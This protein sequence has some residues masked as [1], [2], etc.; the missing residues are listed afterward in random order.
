MWSKRKTVI[1]N[2][3]FAMCVVFQPQAFADDTSPSLKEQLEAIEEQLNKSERTD[4]QEENTHLKELISP[5]QFATETLSTIKIE[6]ESK[7]TPGKDQG[8]KEFGSVTAAIKGGKFTSFSYSS[9]GLDLKEDYGL[10]LLLKTHDLEIKDVEKEQSLRDTFISRNDLPSE[11]GMSMYQEMKSLVPRQEKAKNYT[12]TGMGLNFDFGGHNLGVINFIIPPEKKRKVFYGS[13]TQGPYNLNINSI[14]PGSEEVK[15]EGGVLAKGA[16][17][18]INYTRGEITFTNV[19]PSTQEI[20]IEYELASGSG[21]EPSKFTGFR[22]DNFPEEKS[23][24]TTDEKSNS[25]ETASGGQRSNEER[26]FLY[27]VSYFNDELIRYDRNGDQIGRE[28][29][30]HTLM[31]FDTKYR[32]GNNHS[33][34]MEY[35]GSSGDKQKELGTFATK[36]FSTADTK[37]SDKDPKGPYYLDEDKLPVARDTE[38]ILISGVPVSKDNYS[39]DPTDGRLIFKGNNLN[40]LETDDI[41][42]RYRYLSESDQLGSSDNVR[43]GTA[44]A[45]SMENKFSQ[46]TNS[47]SYQKITPYFTMVGGRS[48]TNILDLRQKLSWRVSDSLGFDM[49]FSRNENLDDAATNLKTVNKKMGWGINFKN[50]DRIYF[51]FK[52]DTD[53]RF[54]NKEIHDTDTD[55]SSRNFSLGYKFNKKYQFSFKGNTNTLTSAKPGAEY[56]TSDRDFSLDIET[57]PFKGFKFDTSLTQGRS[58]SEKKDSTTSSEK[59]GRKFKLRYVPNENIVLFTDLTRNQFRNSGSAD[60]ANQNTRVGLNYKFSEKTTFFT[61]RQ[62]KKDHFSGNEEKSSLNVYDL[63]MKPMKKLD[64]QLKL[65]SLS[66]NRATSDT[67]TTQRTIQAEYQ[68]GKTDKLKMRTIQN[69]QITRVAVIQKDGTMIL[70]STHA[71]TYTVGFNVNPYHKKYPLDFEI[72]QKLTRNTTSPIQDTHETTYKLG[73]EIPFFGKTSLQTD[74][75]FS[76]RSGN[77]NTTEQEFSQSLKGSVTKSGSLSLTFKL[78]SYRDKDEFTASTHESIWLMSGDL[79]W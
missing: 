66:V 70:T 58:S 4:V 16:D 65:N 33:L 1:C 52:N 47:F 79:K 78:K 10:T 26:R 56:S 41:E 40:L 31:G 76:V 8:K 44:Y 6:K 59:S 72:S 57:K 37:A 54:D 20:S 2:V 25:T 48:S 15:V 38:E 9:T 23:K 42:V 22:V 30:D 75:L 73:T 71:M 13:N 19:I 24:D 77:Q 3:L 61:L 21:S 55:K 32:L 27:G 5:V 46:V 11:F 39:L 17:Y 62:D 29:T 18:Q 53:E 28:L 50:G 67:D 12:M 7:P 64:L 51:S 45:F 49:G 69:A 43:S 14:L 35:A 63:K 36:N 34:S 60:N 74:Y 68:P